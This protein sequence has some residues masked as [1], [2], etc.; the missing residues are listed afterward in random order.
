MK[1]K[2]ILR[3]PFK[4]LLIKYLRIDA[5][6]EK[7]F[8]LKKL[9]SALSLKIYG[10]R[11]FFQ[12]FQFYIWIGIPLFLALYF[13]E[14]LLQQ[15]QFEKTKKGYDEFLMVFKF[16]LWLA[17]LSIASGVFF[18]RMHTSTQRAK[19]IEQTEIN[20]NF[21]LFYEHRAFFIEY[22]DEQINEFKK[23]N[24]ENGK[25]QPS[26]IE[27]TLFALFDGI[28]ISVNFYELEIDTKRLY[29]ICYPENNP[30]HFSAKLDEKFI[31]LIETPAIVLS[32][33]T[34]E[35]F[36]LARI[37][38][39]SIF[40][41]V[42]KQCKFSAL[43]VQSVGSINYKELLFPDKLMSKS[44]KSSLEK[45]LLVNSETVAMLLCIQL[46]KDVFHD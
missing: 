20:N 19:S 42:I 33:L 22:V 12:H 25:E 17:G 44:V 15:F 6:V 34:R 11:P 36:S 5:G 26:P 39:M 21:K 27:I 8:L 9:V 41:G 10:E 13:A 1:L 45:S 16:P 28:I 30:T 31:E 3:K 46:V 7:A 23:K 18:S 14:P 38:K 40:K 35:A 43:E 2:K 24:L 32:T 4:W 37:V 29:E